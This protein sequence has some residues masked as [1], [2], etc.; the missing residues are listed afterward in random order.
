[1]VKILHI[2]PTFAPPMCDIIRQIK[3]HTDFQ[4]V[5]ISNNAERFP[6][7]GFVFS[8]LPIYIYDYTKD[9]AETPQMRAFVSKVLEIEK[10]DII[11][12]H[13]FSETAIILNYALTIKNI[14]AMAFIWGNGCFIKNF[15]SPLYKQIFFDNLKVLKKLNYIL[16]TIQPIRDICAANY[17][18]QQSDFAFVGPPI[19]LAQYTDHVP[20]TSSPVLL[21]AKPRGDKFMY[22]NLP[23]VYK[24]FPK[25]T[26]H[27]FHVYPGITLAKQLGLYNKIIFHDYMPQTDFS[28]LIKQCNIVFT[29]TGD[30]GIGG[31]AL[32]ASYAGCVN[33]M[34]QL[35]TS[36]GVLDN[37]IN[38]I[39]CKPKPAD[40]LSKLVYSIQ[41]LPELCKRFKEN[42]RHLIKYD[43]ENTWNALRI[44]ISDCL[45]G[46]KGK[47]VPTCPE[48]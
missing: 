9:Y 28:A 26:V 18:I 29:I 44:A 47:I 10:P 25:L 34:K 33:L 22:E 37:N 43:Q 40:V 46:I 30:A 14:P 8:N 1:V 45:S 39:M 24:R 35:G 4:N 11:I 21:L 23:K 6:M 31:T 17:G 32:Q 15:K 20:N 19:S 2:G 16:I 36:A 42:N 12:G 3:E 13:C 41:N 38:A 48:A 5:V 27:A 7:P